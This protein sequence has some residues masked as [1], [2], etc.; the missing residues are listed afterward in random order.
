M[1]K[2][3]YCNRL[4]KEPVDVPSLAV[5]KARSFEKP[6]V[7]EGVPACGSGVKTR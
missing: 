2:M 4:P 5:F 1:G 6:G 7:V 3:K